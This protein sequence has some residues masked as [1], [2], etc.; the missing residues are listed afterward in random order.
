MSKAEEYHR[1]ADVCRKQA[2][3]A[4]SPAEKQEWLALAASWLRMADDA[5]ASRECSL[6]QKQ[7]G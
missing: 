1:H 3:V 5:L 6:A 4:K 7:P 2:V